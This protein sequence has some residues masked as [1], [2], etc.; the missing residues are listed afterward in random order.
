M[1]DDQ[2]TGVSH[3]NAQ[4]KDPGDRGR[5]VADRGLDLQ[6]GA[7][8]IRSFGR[9]GW[10]GWLEAG[11][12]EAAWSDCSGLDVTAQAGARGMP[13]AAGR[14]ADTGYSHHHGDGQG[15]RVRPACW[16]RD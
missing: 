2:L 15:G 12:V 10:P 7:R 16:I 4:A 9:P 8:R 5:A 11:T 13:G 6:S 3:S 1:R 14:A